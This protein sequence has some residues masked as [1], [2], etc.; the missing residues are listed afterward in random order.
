MGRTSRALAVFGLLV[1]VAT[2]QRPA[3]ERSSAKRPPDAPLPEVVVASG[4]DGPA[5]GD[6]GLGVGGVAGEGA[7]RWDGADVV[8]AGGVRVACRTAGVKLDFPSGRELLLAPDG[9]LHLRSGESGGPF[10]GGCELRLADGCFVRVALSPGAEV[11]VRD[12]VVGDATRRLQPWR[13]GSPN[14]EVVREAGFCGARLLCLGD[15][16]DVYRAIALGPLV[17]LDRVLVPSER[18]AAT[19][20]ERL[21]VLADPIVES[22][23]VM[24]RQHREAKAEVREA[25]RA[26]GALAQQADAI[27]PPGAALQRAERDRLRWLLRGGFAIEYEA[28]G[29]LA[30]RLQ[31]FAG[32]SPLPMVE[33]TLRADSAAFLTNPVDDLS[34]KRWHGNGTR[35]AR[36]AVTLQAR[37]DLYEQGI[38]LAV[39]ERLRK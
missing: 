5:L 13:R 35:L 19:P 20:T 26:I 18:A 9:H 38:A 6:L 28:T 25:M 10:V 16:G 31:L 29:P 30:P 12:V 7:L 1:A 34:G 3:A 37:A 24:Q 21:V 2:A 14:A 33:W 17:T 22:L 39:V 8:T 11:R 36:A 23:H 27:L 4:V 15:G 32:D